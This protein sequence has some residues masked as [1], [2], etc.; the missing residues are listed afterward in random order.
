MKMSGVCSTHGEMTNTARFLPVNMK[1]W[2]T[3]VRGRLIRKLI[4]QIAF[5]DEIKRK[6]KLKTCY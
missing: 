1:D 2:Q 3:D 6:D 5:A 4:G